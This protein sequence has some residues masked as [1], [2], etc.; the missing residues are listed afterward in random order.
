[1]VTLSICALKGFGLSIYPNPVS[2]VLTVENTEG[3]NFQILNLLGQT[4]LRGQTPPL[5]AGGLDVSALPQ[6]SYFLKVGTEQVKF[7][8]Q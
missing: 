7:M 8:K 6:G 4:V 1:M 3:D 5:G 2:N